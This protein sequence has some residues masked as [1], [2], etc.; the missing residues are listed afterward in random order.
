MTH[1][2]IRMR[3]STAKEV[4]FDLSSDDLHDIAKMNN[5]PLHACTALCP[6]ECDLD[7]WY[8]FLGAGPTGPDG[9]PFLMF[10]VKSVELPDYD[11]ED[12]I[13]EEECP[14]EAMIDSGRSVLACCRESGHE[15]LHY[16]NV[17]NVSWKEGTE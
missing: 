4:L 1:I 12:D 5:A 7:G 16:D 11:Q 2:G 14:A 15:G 17:D 3:I 6:P 10:E 8:A 13:D 9:N